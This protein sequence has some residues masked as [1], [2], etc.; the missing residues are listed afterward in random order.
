MRR[1]LAFIPVVLYALTIAILSHIPGLRPPPGVSWADKAVHVL[2]YTGF[3]LALAFAL[4]AQLSDHPFRTIALW[5]LLIGSLYAASDEVH[6]LFVPYRVADVL[7]W[8]ADVTGIGISLLLAHLL[9]Q[10]WKHWL[11][12]E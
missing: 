9:L 4:T 12:T 10:R 2:L 1:R 11:R 6:Q 3:G 7:D 5:T 8:V